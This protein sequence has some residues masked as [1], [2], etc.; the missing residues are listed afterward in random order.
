MTKTIKSII[1]I[2]AKQKVK[3]MEKS[4][5]PQEYAKKIIKY[6]ASRKYFG[7]WSPRNL[8]DRYSELY[9]DDGLPFRD[10]EIGNLSVDSVCDA[11]WT[12]MS[13]NPVRFGTI[14]PFK[15]D[16]RNSIK[17]F[18]NLE[19][20]KNLKSALFEVQYHLNEFYRIVCDIDKNFA[21]TKSYNGQV[22]KIEVDVSQ[23]TRKPIPN[24]SY[25][26]L[27]ELVRA[28][29]AIIK[30]NLEDS[31]IK[32]YFEPMFDVILNKHPNSAKFVSSKP[33]TNENTDLSEVANFMPSQ[34]ITNKN[35]DL[36]EAAKLKLQKYLKQQSKLETVIANK[37]AE[38]S[39][40]QANIDSLINDYENPGDIMTKQARLNRENIIVEKM[41]EQ[42]K[43]IK[44]KIT[45]IQKSQNTL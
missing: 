28:M 4:L 23:P 40:I 19:I 22:V 26:M 1:L 17:D 41:E 33:I 7:N 12:E 15:F 8:Y 14:S 27:A 31:D 43:N 20:D 13:Y 21:Q 24:P 9:K 38:I 36:S 35:T 16:G 10:L 2:L 25:N 18:C 45:N 44:Q 29:R 37:I 6:D 32:D 3:T 30:Q 39:V 11:L 42:L 34:P 5:A